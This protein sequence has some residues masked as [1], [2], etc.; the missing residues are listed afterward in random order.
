[1][2]RRA[3][4]DAPGTL[5][6]VIVRGI[7]KRGIV[8]DR[9]DREALM[10]P[11]GDAATLT[12]TAVYAWSLMANPGTSCFEAGRRDSHDSCGACLRAMPS[13]TTCAMGGT[14]ISSRIVTSPSCGIQIR[15]TGDWFVHSGDS[16][17]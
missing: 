1:M 4:K 14:A 7:D 5:H 17:R 11:R 9:K 13:A 3:R 2:R 16:R 15:W 12:G 8:D 6:H 10:S